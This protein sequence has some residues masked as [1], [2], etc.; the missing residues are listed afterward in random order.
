VC[1]SGIARTWREGDDKHWDRRAAASSATKSGRRWQTFDSKRK[2]SGEYEPA[3]A[4][5]RAQCGPRSS[6][7]IGK[8]A[9]PRPQPPSFREATGHVGPRGT[10]ADRAPAARR[11][12][13]CC[14]RAGAGPLHYAAGRAGEQE[15]GEASVSTVSGPVKDAMLRLVPN[16]RAFAVSLCGNIERADDLV[17]ETLLKAWNNIDD[18]QE[19]TN[20]RAWLF[21]ILRN[22]Y[23][24]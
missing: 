5:D 17:Q 9:T 22:T 19:G 15:Q 23:F 14:R 16:L 4:S 13:R 6:S 10:G 2:N 1:S 21:T 24:S 18:F 20:L 7:V 11:F 3:A 12:R 8:H